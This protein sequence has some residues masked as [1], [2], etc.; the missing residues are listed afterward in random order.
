ML[1]LL[2]AAA[3]HLPASLPPINITVQQPAG[4]LPDWVKIGIGAFLAIVVSLV[5]EFAK[6]S[7]SKARLKRVIARHVGPELMNNMATVESSYRVLRSVYTS[8][9]IEA[10]V[11][12]AKRILSVLGWDRYDLYFGSEKSI[13]YELDEDQLLQR[14]YQVLGQLRLGSDLQGQA[15]WNP[16]ELGQWL[17]AATDIGHKYILKHKLKYQPISNPLETA[18]TEATKAALGAGL[19]PSSPA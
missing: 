17:R 6:P 2:Q 19:G 3:Q 10:Q 5:V 14:F 7:I 12:I 1:L 4:G 8:V 18:F 16:A 15:H 11:D 9:N 13:V